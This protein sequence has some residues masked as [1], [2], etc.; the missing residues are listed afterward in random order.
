[1]KTKRMLEREANLGEWRRVG[2]DIR[3][4]MYIGFGLAGLF[5]L[6]I[7]I[8]FLDNANLFDTFGEAAKATFTSVFVVFDIY[9]LTVWLSGG[10]K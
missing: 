3:Y 2:P 1:M 6:S 8:Y 10:N 9:I 5:L 4:L 7:F